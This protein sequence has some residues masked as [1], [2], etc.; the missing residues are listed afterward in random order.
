MILYNATFEETLPACCDASICIESRVKPIN[1]NFASISM[2]LNS[3]SSLCVI[4]S[5]LNKDFLEA[6]LFY[7]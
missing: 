6:Q 7:N 3:V 1:Y 5:V 4:S 2:L